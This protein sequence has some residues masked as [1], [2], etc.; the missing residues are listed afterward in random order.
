MLRLLFRPATSPLHTFLY[1]LLIHSA[2]LSLYELL[3]F[4]ETK[5]RRR[6][7]L[8]PGHGNPLVVPVASRGQRA[9]FLHRHRHLTNRSVI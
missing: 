5:S 7:R 9:A 8:G 1:L 2:I 4:S 6:P 3:E